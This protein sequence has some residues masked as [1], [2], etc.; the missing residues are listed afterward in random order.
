ESGIYLY[1]RNI[2]HHNTH[3]IDTSNTVNGRVIYYFSNL[4]SGTIP[5]DA[6]QV[7]LAKCSGITVSNLNLN[8][9]CAGLILGFSHNCT[10]V[11]NTF[12]DNYYSVVL[13]Y[14]SNNT[15]RWNTLSRNRY[16]GIKLEESH[17]NFIS[18]NTIEENEDSGIKLLSS[19]GNTIS[20][21][22]INDNGEEGIY[23][24]SG[25]YNTSILK[26][27]ISGNAEGIRIH[28]SFREEIY[29]IH[30]CTISGNIDWGI[31]VSWGDKVVNATNNYWGDASGPYHSENNS[32]GMGDNVTD[33][34][35]FEPWLTTPPNQRPLASII[36]IDPNPVNQGEIVTF[37]GHGTDDG[38][39]V[40][41]S[42]R[43]SINKEIYNNTE[44]TFNYANLSVG[45]HIIYLKVQDN[46]GVWSEEVTATL[47]VNPVDTE[48]PIL[49]ITSP[50]NGAKV[51]GNITISGTASDDVGILKVEYRISGT[52]E[53]LQAKGT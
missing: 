5:S 51:K 6:G 49:T 11:S 14:S 4:T 30:N 37:T 7:I 48:L 47:T 9:T 29:Q 31:Y 38:T 12:T 22:F 10:I 45:V 25:S 2:E 18:G 28:E 20:E 19:T 34:V 3:T 39:I 53:W 32:D 23:I 26:C 27:T 16:N 46:L 17:D 36:S 52:D 24:D 15:L 42:W 44:Y 35:I 50:K 33:M 8:Q 21:C 43:S 1:G 13:Q 41:Y 40:K